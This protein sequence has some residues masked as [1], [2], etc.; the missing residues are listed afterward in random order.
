MDFREVF[1]QAPVPILIV[2]GGRIVH[3]NAAAYGVFRFLGYEA[4]D[5]RIVDIDTLMVVAPEEREEVRRNMER[6]LGAGQTFRNI[7]RT[8]VDSEGNRIA[9][10]V[11]AGPCAWEGQPGQEVSFIILGLGPASEYGGR[12]RA[13]LP[14]AR[15]GLFKALTPQEGRVALLLAEGHDTAEIGRRLGIQVSTLRGYIKSIYLKLEVH[16]RSELVRRVL[17][18]R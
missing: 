17:G 9:T 4:S 13:G 14:D 11:S 15:A 6:I 2:Q 8:L 16:S 5:E 12:A 10:L 3:C 1:E 18:H 7:P